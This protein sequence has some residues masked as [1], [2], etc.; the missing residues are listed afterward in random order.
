MAVAMPVRQ[1]PTF[2]EYELGIVLTDSL[3]L[4]VSDKSFSC[5]HRIVQQNEK[6]VETRTGSDHS[7]GLAKYVE[8]KSK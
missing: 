2:D 4:T 6:V 8:N 5:L 3:Q 7:L 1:G